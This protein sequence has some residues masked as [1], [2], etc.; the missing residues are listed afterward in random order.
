PAI[1]RV[2]GGLDAEPAPLVVV[3]LVVG[4]AG[5]GLPGGHLH[6]EQELHLPAGFVEQIRDAVAALGDAE[7]AVTEGILPR[8]DVHAALEEGLER[9]GADA[10]VHHVLAVVPGVVPAAAHV[11]HVVAGPPPAGHGAIAEVPG[12][13]LPEVVV[14]EG[15]D[16]DVAD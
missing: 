16:Y 5:E 10:T 6:L 11:E 9:P 1:G 14:H 15:T 7:G 13:T 4:H 2:R 12:L 3:D 8:P